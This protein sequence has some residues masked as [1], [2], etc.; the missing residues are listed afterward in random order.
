MVNVLSLICENE[1]SS[2]A[3]YVVY[4]I[5]KSFQSYTENAIRISEENYHELSGNK[6]E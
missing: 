4:L 6:G 5:L 3:Y 2:G 1:C